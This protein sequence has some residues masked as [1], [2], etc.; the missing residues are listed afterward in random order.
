[1]TTKKA[2]SVMLVLMFLLGSTFVIPARYLGIQKKKTSPLILRSQD[3]LVALKGDSNRNNVPDWKDLVDNSISTTTKV[4]LAKTPVSEEDKKRLNDPNNLTASFSKNAYTASAYANKNGTLTKQQQDELASS[5]LAGEQAK[6]VHK[7]Y[8][9]KDLN[10]AKTETDSSRKSYGNTLGIIV[11]AALK[12]KSSSD[13]LAIIKAYSV[14]KDET[15]LSALIIKRD[16]IG[17]AIE[18]LLATPVPYSAVPYHLMLINKLSEYKDILDNMSQVKNDPLRASIALNS[19]V[20]V[21]KSLFT[22]ITALQSYFILEN[23][24]FTKKEPGYLL[25]GG[26]PQ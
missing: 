7:T 19:Y 10:I 2:L 13:D 1:M 5:L 25:T 20:D 8:E 12:N 14:N 24:T 9:V 22:S 23:I 17:V 6:I 11:Q 4:E 26:T 21:V 18:K 3:E 16:I 15:V